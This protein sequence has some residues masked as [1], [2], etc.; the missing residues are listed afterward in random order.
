MIQVT[1]RLFQLLEL[2]G[3]HGRLGSKA[4][5]DA[6]GLNH[7]TTCNLLASLVEL[8]YVQRNAAHEYLFAPGLYRLVEQDLPRRVLLRHGPQITAQACTRLGERTVIA[9]LEGVV[10]NVICESVYADGVA[11][12]TEARAWSEP[13]DSATGRMLVA[14][15]AEPARTRALEALGMPGSSWDGIA[16]QDGLAEALAGVRAQPVHVLMR[17]N[18]SCAVAVAV[19]DAQGRV[20]AALGVSLPAARWSEAH[21]DLVCATLVEG[22]RQLGGLLDSGR[23]TTPTQHP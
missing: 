2:I 21:R 8:G 6:T 16:T 4:L 14:H 3:A 12:S 13:W 17:A 18:G 5:A 1:N 15:L 23:A 20:H 22:A 11:T 10:L 19:S 9:V 7:S